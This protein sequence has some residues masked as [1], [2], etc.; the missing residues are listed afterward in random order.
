M[1]PYTS[2][3]R[4]ERAFVPSNRMQMQNPPGLEFSIGSVLA[5]RGDVRLQ[6][7]NQMWM[8]VFVWCLFSS[9][10]IYSTAAVLAF[11]A[12]RK[13]SLGRF[14]SVMILVMGLIIPLSLGLLSSG[15]IAFVYKHSNFSMVPIHAM[16]WGV[17]QTVTHAAV[18]FTRILATL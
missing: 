7:F 13:H 18:G 5:L 10:V 8:A 4:L 3:D 1:D 14:Y 2:N 6:F 9:A 16:M 11:A 12:L 15:A 17:G